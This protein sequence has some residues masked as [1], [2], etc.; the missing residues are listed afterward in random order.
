MMR[1]LRARLLVA[2]LS[3]LAASAVLAALAIL[4]NTQL[5]LIVIAGLYVAESASSAPSPSARR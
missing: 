3:L 4:T 5:L 1:S 2:L